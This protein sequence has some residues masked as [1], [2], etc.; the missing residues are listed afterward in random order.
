MPLILVANT[1]SDV[2]F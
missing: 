1:T 2:I